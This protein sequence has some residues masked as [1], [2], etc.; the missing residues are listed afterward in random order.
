VQGFID[1]VD[2]RYCSGYQEDGCPY[3]TPSCQQTVG[4][5]VRGKCTAVPAPFPGPD[6]LPIDPRPIRPSAR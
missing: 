3:S 1:H 6:P 4:A 5:C 2:E